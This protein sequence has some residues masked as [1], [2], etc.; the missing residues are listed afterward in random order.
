MVVLIFGDDDGDLMIEPFAEFFDVP[1]DSLAASIRVLMLL[2]VIISF[3]CFGALTGDLI[4]TVFSPSLLSTLLLDNFIGRIVVV[5]VVVVCLLFVFAMP[6]IG[7]NLLRSL[8]DAV[9]CG[10]G[11]VIRCFQF[12]PF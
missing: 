6:F 1:I 11:D 8:F 12:F 7:S 3:I 10:R 4:Y 2:L 5:V 9:V